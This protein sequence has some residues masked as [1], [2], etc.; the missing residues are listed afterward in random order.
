VLII[1]LT[2]EFTGVGTIAAVLPKI[3]ADPVQRRLGV[4]RRRLL[5]LIDALVRQFFSDAAGWFVP[6]G[7]YMARL[8]SAFKLL[9]SAYRVE[10]LSNHISWFAP[11]HGAGALT[12]RQRVRLAQRPGERL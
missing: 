11:A 3:V 12:A 6:R 9:A 2:G 10:G 4:N 5:G 8:L 1:A 7:H